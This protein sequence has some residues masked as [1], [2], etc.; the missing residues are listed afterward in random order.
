MQVQAT[1]DLDSVNK[2]KE[3][4]KCYRRS[5]ETLDR[6]ILPNARLLS[7]ANGEVLEDTYKNEKSASA[8]SRGL[9]TVTGLILVIALGYTQIF[10]AKR[11]RRRVNMPLLVAT[12]GLLLFLLRLS[13]DLADSSHA[14]QV[15]K[16]DA[17]NSMIALFDA[18][19]FASEANACESRWLLDPQHAA[20]HKKAFDEKVRLIANFAGG[21]NF[22]ETVA[23]ARR[24]QSTKKS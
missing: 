13:S 11:F 2:A 14:L 8:L 18:K 7:Q 22:E 19:C 1:R 5:L 3:A 20:V 9:V 10:L 16:E 6:E 12:L 21:H 23:T 24:Q 4:L 15:A 17:Y